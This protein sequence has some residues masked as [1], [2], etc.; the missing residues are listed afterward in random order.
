VTGAK[1]IITFWHQ[2]HWKGKKSKRKENELAIFSQLPVRGICQLNVPKFVLGVGA[3]ERVK[4]KRNIKAQKPL[5][6]VSR[7]WIYQI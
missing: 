5:I 2:L 4:E 7:F 1:Q 6:T 3:T